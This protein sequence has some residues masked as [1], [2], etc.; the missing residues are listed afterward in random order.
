MTPAS[1]TSFS[2][3]ALGL[4]V[5]ALGSTR[6]DCFPDGNAHCVSPNHLASVSAAHLPRPEVQVVS[7]P[8]PA[9]SP[10]R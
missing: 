2:T 4:R 8:G 10:V 1:T 6:G 5:V 7:R 9:A 3:A